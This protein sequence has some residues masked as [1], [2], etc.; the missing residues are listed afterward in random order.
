M[1]TLDFIMAYEGGELEDEQQLIDGFQ[2]LID[3]GLAW[4]L[5]G[6]YGRTAKALIDAGECVD[7]H[8]VLGGQNG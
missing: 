6:H 8:G 4:K 7:T 3:E 1:T 2:K 5:Q